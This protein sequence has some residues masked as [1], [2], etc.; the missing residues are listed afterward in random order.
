MKRLDDHTYQAPH[1]VLFTQRM[2]E[3]LERIQSTHPTLVQVYYIYDL[4]TQQ[5]LY[6]TGSVPDMLGYSADTVHEMGP[7]G[8]AKLIDPDD[9]DSVAEHYQQFYTLNYGDVLEIKY[10]MQ[11]ADGTWCRLRSEATPS[12]SESANG[13]PVQVLGVIQPISQVAVYPSIY[14]PF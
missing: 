1:T 4:T 12:M 13:F 14:S 9:L 6:A 8:L 2:I 10:R 11:R 5:I 3:E 7:F